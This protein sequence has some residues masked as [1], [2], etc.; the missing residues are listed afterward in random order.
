MTK[1]FQYWYKQ[2]IK[3]CN[4]RCNNYLIILDEKLNDAIK[5]TQ[6][7]V[8]IR[9]RSD[10]SKASSLDDKILSSNDNI[11]SIKKNIKNVKKIQDDMH[12]AKFK[13]SSKDVYDKLKNHPNIEKI[14]ITQQK[15]LNIYTKVLKVNDS[16]IGNFKL[17]YDL[18]GAYYIRNL[19]YIVLGVYDH[20]HVQR[21]E[22]CLSSWRP[23]LSRQLDTYQIFLFVDTLIH[24][25]LLSSSDHAYLSFDKWLEKFR[26]KE[27]VD[28][29]EKE[30]YVPLEELVDN[31]FAQ[32]TNSFWI[33]ANTSTVVANTGHW[34]TW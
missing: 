32:S 12:D 31:A 9:T 28:I 16:E 27:K 25:L 19:E 10:W 26:A 23:I 34:G 5:T 8:D 4:S 33:T 18:S 14:V 3:K 6:K 29:S 24:Y 21:G 13:L 17:T 30:K 7:I 2:Y 22:P 1:T 15:C 20:W 11:Y